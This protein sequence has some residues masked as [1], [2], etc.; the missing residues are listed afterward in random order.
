MFNHDVLNFN[1]EKFDLGAFNPN[2]RGKID[3]SLGVGLRRT[4]SGEPIAIV[5]DKYEPVQYLDLVENV[6]EAIPLNSF[7]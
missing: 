4:D 3:P 7:K 6:E 1:V 2:F 5:S